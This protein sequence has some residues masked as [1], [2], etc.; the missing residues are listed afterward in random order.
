[1]AV[2]AH[3][4]GLG[5]DCRA[6]G[7]AAPLSGQS[8][9]SHGGVHFAAQPVMPLIHRIIAS[10]RSRWGLVAV[11]MAMTLTA[12]LGQWAVIDR[13]GRGGKGT[14]AGAGGNSTTGTG[15]SNTGGNGKSGGAPGTGG[16][17][18]TGGAGSGSGGTGG[19]SPGA[20]GG[21]SAGEGGGGGQGPSDAGMPA[22]AGC[23]IPS[24]QLLYGE[25][26]CGANAPAPR[27]LPVYLCIQNA[28]SCDGKVIS[29]CYGFRSAFAYVY[30]LGFMPDGGSCDPNAP[31]PTQ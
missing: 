4:T 1:M 10:P 8:Q 29:G 12:C 14:G 28:C 16:R 6:A 11:L 31:P 5:Q 2:A 17:S 15:G 26:G 21:G 22:D 24:S 27:C 9:R 18:E 30:P 23:M 20:A 19:E 7:A 25:R 13:G 3:Q